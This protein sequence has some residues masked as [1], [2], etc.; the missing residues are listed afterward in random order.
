MTVTALAVPGWIWELGTSLYSF[1]FGF[2]LLKII[3]KTMTGLRKKKTKGRFLSHFSLS[4]ILLSEF[5]RKGEI[6]QV[7]APISLFTSQVGWAELQS[8]AANTT[9][10]VPVSKPSLPPSNVCIS[11]MHPGT[12]RGHGTQVSCWGIWAYW[13]PSQLLRQVPPSL[14]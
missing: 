1:L 4:F 5:G 9:K 2:S 11:K 3:A 12:R 10:A 14:P 13:L 8:G 6:M 7:R